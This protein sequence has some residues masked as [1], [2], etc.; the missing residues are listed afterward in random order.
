[1]I[2]TQSGV[3]AGYRFPDR[4]YDSPEAI[5]ICLDCRMETC[6]GKCVRNSLA[7]KAARQALN[8]VRKNAGLPPDARVGYRAAY[9]TVNGVT[10]TLTGWSGRTGIHISTLYCRMKKGMSMAE[11]IACQKPVPLGDTPVTIDG[12]TRTVR[13]WANQCGCTVS[14]IHFRMC[15]KGESAE[16]AV[17]HFARRKQTGRRK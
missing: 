2:M 3:K 16:A 9:Y 5:Q 7:N 17:G 11:A 6:T 4:Q 8:E 10:D 15:R 1:M 13:E 12:V 14:G